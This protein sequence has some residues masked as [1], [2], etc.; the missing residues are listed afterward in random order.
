MTAGRPLKADS[1][2][3]SSFYRGRIL[4]YTHEPRADASGIIRFMVKPGQ[5]VKK[6]QPVARIYNVL[7]KLQSTLEATKDGITLGHSDSSV[8]FPGAEVV[9]FGVQ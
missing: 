9:A 5:V 8:A 2:E 7:G 1:T 4:K 6:G 3:S